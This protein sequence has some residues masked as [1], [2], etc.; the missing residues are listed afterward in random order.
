MKSEH[1]GVFGAL[2]DIVSRDGHYPEGEG[3]EAPREEVGRTRADLHVSNT[4]RLSLVTDGKFVAGLITSKGV[5][6]KREKPRM[7]A[8]SK[9]MSKGGIALEIQK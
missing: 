1:K 7:R 4:T 5:P 3:G 9:I 8:L 6:A 2:F